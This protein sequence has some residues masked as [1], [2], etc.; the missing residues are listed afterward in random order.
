ME[1]EMLKFLCANQGAADAEDLI[2]NLFPGKST[3]EV[4]S[5]P[6]KFA[7]CS[8]NGKQRVVARTSLKLCR[9]K[10]CPEPCGGLHLCKNFLYSGCCQFLLRRGCSFP[11][12]LDSVY[13]QT[14]LREHE[15]EALSR[16]ELCMLLLQSD[17]SMLPSV[18][19]TISTTYSDY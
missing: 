14:L 19:P 13:N 10:D 15:L 12:S 8:S 16:E 9:K 18:S 3:N 6:S 17:H 1:T 2:C 5:N 4:V 11:H 7:L